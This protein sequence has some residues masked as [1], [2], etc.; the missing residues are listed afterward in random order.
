MFSNTRRKEFLKDPLKMLRGVIINFILSRPEKFDMR[1]GF[2]N[3]DLGSSFK[4]DLGF[5]S[6]EDVAVLI[7]KVAK[8]LKIEI[9]LSGW[10]EEHLRT[11]NDLVE[12]SKKRFQ[13]L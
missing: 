10:E 7:E 11:V 8:K 6:T 12:V 2:D 4:E 9:R 1:V 13:G 3:I 5:K